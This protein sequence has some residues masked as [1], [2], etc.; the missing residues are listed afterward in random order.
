MHGT[1]VR[2]V[3]RRR[4]IAALLVSWWCVPAGASAD[5]DDP[6]SCL[7]RASVDSTC[8]G[9]DDDCSGQ[10]DEDFVGGSAAC[11]VGACVRRGA[12]TCTNGVIHNACTPLNP[13]ANDE[14]CNGVDD[15]CDGQ[16]DEEFATSVC[17]PT[18]ARCL[19]G[20]SRCFSG[21]RSCEPAAS[22]R[23]DQDRDGVDDALDLDDDN[24][25]LPDPLEGKGDPD[26]DGLGNALDLDSDGDGIVDLF[27]A[28][29]ARFD[30]DGDAV[31]NGALGDNGLLDALELRRDNGA[32]AARPVDTDG[33]GVRDELDLDSDGD[34]IADL[35]EVDGLSSFDRDH[36]GRLDNRTDDDLDGLTVD[37][38]RDNQYGYPRID[39]RATDRDA[40]GIPRVY[41]VADD[42]PGAGDSDADGVRDDR[43]C[44]AGWPCLDTDADGTPDYMDRDRGNQGADAGDELDTDSDAVA[45]DR[46]AGLVA[47]RDASG[48]QADSDDDGVADTTECPAP[49][50]RDTDGD[51]LL[52]QR[53]PDDDGDGVPTRDE[54]ARGDSDGDGTP[55]HLDGDD[56]GDGVLTKDEVGDRDRDGIPDRLQPPPTVSLAGGALCSAWNGRVS[57]TSPV[58]VLLGALAALARRVVHR[59]TR[60]RAG[61]CV[62]RS[63]RG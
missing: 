62:S 15:D 30:A 41:D 3:S 49:P 45:D 54:R 16:V 33:D 23:N 57:T 37:A 9:V 63:P 46:D 28:G 27:E 48:A 6:A 17:V 53:D 22:C 13:A 21:V 59:R 52:D 60:G 58:L 10:V 51:G 14:S 39:P 12:L 40:D 44:P 25:G 29:L 61:D 56:D 19:H 55:D 50:C 42:G 7:P 38:D 4:L 2:S 5:A 1:V 31:V 11:G 26:A 32:Y 24:D 47:S 8:D 36:D 20:T 35:D 34:G 43:E 18:L